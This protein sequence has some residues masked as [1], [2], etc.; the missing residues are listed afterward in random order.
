MVAGADGAVGRLVS[1]RLAGLGVAQRLLVADRARAPRFTGA[2]VAEASYDDAAAMRRALAGAKAFFLA[3]AK[4]SHD[5]LQEHV[6][7]IDAAITAGVERLVYVSMVGAAANATYTLARAHFHAEQHARTTGVPSTFL[8]TSQYLDLLPRF[9][10]ADGLIQN[11]AGEGRVACLSRDDL[12]DVAVAVLTDDGHAGRTYDVTGSAAQTMTEIAYQLARASGRPISYVRK[13]LEETQ[14][15]LG[16]G[17]TG[18]WCTF[19][20]AV[21]AGEMDV[22]S[23]TVASLTGHDPQTFAEYL[24]DHPESYTHLVAG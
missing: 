19:F 4:E 9:C 5:L 20:A 14:T 1:S 11:R 16:A 24:R 7:A 17:G 22:V 2:E 13:T 8:R 3:P 12:A 18:D 21:A 10:S 6:A 23:D 15:S